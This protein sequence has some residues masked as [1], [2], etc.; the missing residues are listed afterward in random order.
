M[1]AGTASG[2]REA[3]GEVQQLVAQ[4]FRVGVCE[5]TVEAER[6]GPDEQVVCEADDLMPHLVHGEGLERELGKDGGLVV[7]DPVLD[8]GVLTVAAL[9][10]RDVLAGLVCEERLEAVAIMVGEGQLRTEVRALATHDRPAAR[11]PSAQLEPIGELNTLAVASSGPIGVHGRD[12]VI[13][14]GFQDLGMNLLGQLIADRE[15]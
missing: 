7:T 4:A 11:R 8:V 1:Q 14:R 6:L 5:L 12:P 15:P 3:G 9:N 10:L 13:R 2:E